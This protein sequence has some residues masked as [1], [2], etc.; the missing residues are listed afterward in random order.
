MP[1]LPANLLVALGRPDGSSATILV[2]NEV[3]II[4][5]RKECLVVTAWRSSVGVPSGLAILVTEE[6]AVN[7]LVT[8]SE[9]DREDLL[10][11]EIAITLHD[12]TLCV[13]DLLVGALPGAAVVVVDGQL[14]IVLHAELDGAIFAEDAHADHEPVAVFKSAVAHFE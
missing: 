8:K 7:D 11:A 12:G 3:S 14:A 13:A 4:L 10:D 6:N 2:Q 1:S 9:Q 5:D